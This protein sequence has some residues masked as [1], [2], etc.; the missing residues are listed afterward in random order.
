M[1]HVSGPVSSVGRTRRGKD[2]DLGG[3]VTVSRSSGSI[4]G[5]DSG[6]VGET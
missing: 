4:T 5:E 6:K 1:T 3:R 2:V